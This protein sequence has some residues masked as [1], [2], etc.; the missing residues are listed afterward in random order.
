M[1]TQSVM[2][3][4]E[5]PKKKPPGRPF[6][7][8]QSGN[9]SGRAKKTPEMRRIEDLARQHS[10]EAIMALLDEAKRGRGPSRV[11]A[12]VAILDRGWGRPMERQESGGPGSF[13]QADEETLK[14]RIKERS[15]R[16]GLAKVVPIKDA[17]KR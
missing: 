16:L 2:G 11:T 13:E 8:G 7:K 14:K 15:V 12:A 5:P 6:V 3:E 10:E 17:K 9:P 1:T 4:S